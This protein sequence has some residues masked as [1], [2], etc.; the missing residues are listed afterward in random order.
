MVPPSL[1]YTH[2]AIPFV[3]L[4]YVMVVQA[5]FE[6]SMSLPIGSH[7]EIFLALISKVDK[8][9]AAINNESKETKKTLKF[10]QPGR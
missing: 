4:T 9:V 8:E 10:T 6:L 7:N 5:S 2:D 1:A 3:K